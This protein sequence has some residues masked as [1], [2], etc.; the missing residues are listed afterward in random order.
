MGS[1]YIYIYIHITVYILWFILVNVHLYIFFA[2]PHADFPPLSP[3][4]QVEPS[5][6]F[7][8]KWCA[9]ICNEWKINFLILA[10]FSFWDMVN[11][12][13]LVDCFFYH[14]RCAMLGNKFFGSSKL[15]VANFRFWDMVVALNIRSEL[16]WE[17]DEFRQ[18]IILTG[19]HPQAPDSSRLNPPSQLIIGYHWLAFLNPEFVVKSIIQY[20]SWV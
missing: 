19:L 1:E 4:P 8:L 2:F 5:F 7:G 14:K 15:F 16:V 18:K 17:L 11:L 3:P 9:M 10:I 6:L 12:N 20:E 13:H